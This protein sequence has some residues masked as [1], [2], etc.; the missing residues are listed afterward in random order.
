MSDHPSKVSPSYEIFSRMAHPMELASR[1]EV[2]AAALGLASWSLALVGVVPWDDA[3][4][5]EGVAIA[6]CCCRGTYGLNKAN[7]TTKPIYEGDG[8]HCSD[9]LREWCGRRDGP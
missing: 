3:G 1:S 5:A 6:G 4:G 7:T 9:L 2:C 8:F